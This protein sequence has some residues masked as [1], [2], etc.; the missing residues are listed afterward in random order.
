VLFPA[1]TVLAQGGGPLTGSLPETDPVDFAFRAGP[2]LLLP[3]ITLNQLGVDSNVFNDAANPKSDFVAAATPA[4]T[5]YAR[6]RFVRFSAMTAATFTYFKR[7]GSERSIGQQLKGRA[8]LLLSRVR[9]FGAA[10]RI[11]SYDR[12]NNEI[13]ARAQHIDDE[14]TG[15]V[16]VEIS[17]TTNAYVSAMKVSTEYRGG[18]LFRGVPLNAAL[19]R[20]TYAYEAGFRTALTPLTQASFQAAV[21]HD[22]FR[23]DTSRNSRSRIASAQLTFGPE[24]IIRGTAKVGFRTFD[25]DDPTVAAYEGLMAQVGLSYSVRERGRL[26]GAFRRDV[27]YSYDR[28]QSYYVDTGWDA[29]YTHR[30][31]GGFDATAGGAWDRM[32][33]GHRTG[34]PDRLD[35]ARALTA[36]VGYNFRD[37]SRLGL[38]YEWARRRSDG[39]VLLNYSRTRLF[40]S[41]AFTF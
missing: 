5:A 40:A 30:L 21:S 36:G 28:V 29:S 16:G 4:M 38:N 20:D 11:N 12:V 25:A 27:Q 39:E 7:Y 24:A 17:P 37:R 6:L 19:N 18:E 14:L 23:F 31:A 13:D 41:W 34:L 8:D 10:G 1:A 3:S 9:P 32:S 2:V 26:Q 35:T 15:G 33:Y 22:A